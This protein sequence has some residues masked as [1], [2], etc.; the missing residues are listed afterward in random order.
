MKIKLDENLSEHLQSLLQQRGHDASSTEQE[1][2]LGR[3]DA[4]VAAAAGSEGRMVFTLD[5]GFAELR[6]FPPGS[7]P[8]V[9]LFRPATL[10]FQAVSRFVQTFVESEDLTQFTGCIVVVDQNRVRVRRPPAPAE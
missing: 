2:L 5:V 9:V 7:H 4:E 6:K 1:G 10:G 3:S 8:G